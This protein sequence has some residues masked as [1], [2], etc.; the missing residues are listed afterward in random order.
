[1]EPSLKNRGE[2]CLRLESY[3][4]TLEN[5]GIKMDPAL[6]RIAEYSNERRYEQTEKLLETPRKL[7]ASIF[8]RGLTTLGR[9]RAIK[10]LNLK[11]REDLSVVSFYEIIAAELLN[12][13]LIG[14]SSSN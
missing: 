2:R 1:V 10:E 5:Y 14:Y 3:I 12:S 7:T 6:I 11:V 9:I 8:V 4:E 13:S